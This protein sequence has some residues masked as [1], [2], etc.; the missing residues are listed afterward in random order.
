VLLNLNLDNAHSDIN[1]EVLRRSTRSSYRGQRVR[2]SRSSSSY[3][4]DSGAGDNEDGDYFCL[5]G[6]GARAGAAQDDDYVD[7]SEAQ[8]QQQRSS[9]KQRSSASSAAVRDVASEETSGADWEAEAEAEGELLQED[10]I[11]ALCGAAWVT[12]DTLAAFLDCQVQ[13]LLQTHKNLTGPAVVCRTAGADAGA[14]AGA[15]AGT[16]A[17]DEVALSGQMQPHCSEVDTAETLSVVPPPAPAPAQAQ[18]VSNQVSVPKKTPQ[19]EQHDLLNMMILCDGC[20]GSYHM[21]CVGMLI[22]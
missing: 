12:E 6:T 19:Q 16:G 22:L 21:V 8:N 15:G 5:G 2:F 18:A 17:P 1:A 4:D 13:G 10:D 3:L 20:E 14:S 9:K 11:C 7:P